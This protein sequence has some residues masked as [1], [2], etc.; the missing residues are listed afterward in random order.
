M[1]E[2]VEYDKA[3][4][5]TTNPTEVGR[6][7]STLYD[8]ICDNRFVPTAL[9]QIIGAAAHVLIRGGQQEPIPTVGW[10]P[11]VEEARRIA[12]EWL[13]GKGLGLPFGTGN[14]LD[15]PV[16]V[17]NSLIA[18]AEHLLSKQADSAE[19][20][21]D[22]LIDSR[23]RA[24]EAADRLAYAIASVEAI[25]EHSSAN[26]PW[27]N[28]LRYAESLHGFKAAMIALA[29]RWSVAA[30]GA[31]LR[32]G[33]AVDSIFAAMAR[34]DMTKDEAEHSLLGRLVRELSRLNDI[35]HAPIHSI[36]P[37]D[38]DWWASHPVRAN[39]TPAE[40]AA[41]GDALGHVIGWLRGRAAEG[42]L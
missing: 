14:T 32:P 42:R 36:A 17:V 12:T 7:L 33:V 21:M 40:Q 18:A 39:A 19:R 8:E 35:G 1:T 24:T 25:G 5:S 16:G 15:D 30:P 28:A 22:N 34:P 9:I 38:R 23:D 29:E 27:E 3:I 41:L 10:D 11:R 37:E 6:A 4:M 2:R 31:V 26:D 20:E 13:G